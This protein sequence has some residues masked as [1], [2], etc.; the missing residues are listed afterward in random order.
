LYTKCARKFLYV[1]RCAA[2]QES[3]RTTD[4]GHAER[5]YIAPTLQTIIPTV[6]CSNLRR[7]TSY[8]DSGLPWF[9]SVPPSKLRNNTR[10]GHDHFLPNTF[11]FIVHYSFYRSTLCNVDTNSAVKQH[12]TEIARTVS[13]VNTKIISSI[14]IINFN[15]RYRSTHLLMSR[16]V[17]FPRCLYLFYIFLVIGLRFSIIILRSHTIYYTM[18]RNSIC[19]IIIM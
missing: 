19:K 10:L 11:Q 14:G 4:V 7:R 12:K 17:H 9:S 15:Y 13:I 18:F 16:N 2:N 3:W 1:L 8:P 5:I 6:L